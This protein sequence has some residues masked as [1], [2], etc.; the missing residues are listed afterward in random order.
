MENQPFPTLSVISDRSELS[1]I[2]MIVIRDQMKAKMGRG[3][4]VDRGQEAQD[5]LMRMPLLPFLT[6]AKN[7]LNA[8]I[9]AV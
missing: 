8:L 7:A 1:G 6:L 2:G 4:A 3:L 5:F 9:G